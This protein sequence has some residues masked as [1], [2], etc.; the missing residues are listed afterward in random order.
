VAVVGRR[1]HGADGE[2]FDVEADGIREVVA[3][4][5]V[6]G[7]LLEKEVHEH[8]HEASEE[9]GGEQGETFSS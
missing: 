1:G 4:C 5:A 9:A 8:A 7:I 2:H 3:P 6:V